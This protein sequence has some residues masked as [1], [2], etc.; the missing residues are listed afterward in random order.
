MPPKLENT[1]LYVNCFKSD[2]D[3]PVIENGGLVL[4]IVHWSTVLVQSPLHINHAHVPRLTPTPHMEKSS[5]ALKCNTATLERTSREEKRHA[6]PFAA[7]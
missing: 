4:G 2:F 7:Q 1:N 6:K 3:R 5:L